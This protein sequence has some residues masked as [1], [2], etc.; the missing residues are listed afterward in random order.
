MKVIHMKNLSLGIDLGGT[1]ILGI[2]VDEKYKII[3][4]DKVK[5]KYRLSPEEICRQMKGIADS[6]LS[7]AG[8]S[9]NDVKNIGIAVPASIDPATGD[10]LHAPALGWKDLPIKQ[11][12]EDVF[13]RKIFLEND[14][15]CGTYAEFKLGAGKG[16][17]N[18][19]GYFVGTG[20]GGGV[21]IDGKLLRG[22]RG[23][24]G[25]L[26]HEVVKMDGRA[27]GCGK[28]GCIEAYCSK[29]AFGKQF[30]KQ[31][32]KKKRSSII[33]KYYEGDF[34]RLKSKAF[35]KA[36][37]AGD[38]VTMEILEDGFKAL[39]I[40]ASNIA[41]I[42]APECIVLGGGVVEGVGEGVLPF[43]QKSFDENLF[44]LKPGDI[45]IRLSKLGDDAV[46]LGAIFNAVAKG[47]I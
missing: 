14:V 27:C 5:T 8:A 3:S 42:L 40:A 9:W 20:L 11:T 25:E 26:G 28:N 33:T 15:N 17:K 45:A 7:N 47:K 35:A 44:A 46:P 4:Q 22:T 39:G 32:R 24:A 43:F 1:K 36:F 16:F 37:A 34:T 29:T 6:A 19:V 23:V 13:G 10:G 41:T 12:L 21:V 2:V 31:I 38:E 18:V 30:D